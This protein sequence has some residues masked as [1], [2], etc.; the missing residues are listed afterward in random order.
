MARA[1]NAKIQRNQIRLKHS[2]MAD[3][4][5]ND[6]IPDMMSEFEAGLGRGELLQLQSG[7]ADI[8]DEISL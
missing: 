4:E 7:A 1:I 8:W 5:I 2:I 3:I 6:T